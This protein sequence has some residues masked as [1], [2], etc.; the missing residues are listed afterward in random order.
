MSEWLGKPWAQF[1]HMFTEEGGPITAPPPRALEGLMLNAWLHLQGA[2]RGLRPQQDRGR[3]QKSGTLQRRMR[4]HQE[5]PRQGGQ[6]HGW[7]WGGATL[8]L[9]SKQVKPG[10]GRDRHTETRESGREPLAELETLWSSLPSPMEPQQ[11][12]ALD[13][14]PHTPEAPQHDLKT[15]T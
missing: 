5:G 9:E 7:T 3:S 2:W 4:T 15:C 12:P 10:T 8:H 1:L 13:P 6:A 14:F 11:C